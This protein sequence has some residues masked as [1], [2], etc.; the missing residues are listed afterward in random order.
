VDPLD[1]TTNFAHSYPCFCVSIGLAE[2]G[3]P[4]AGAVF[5]PVAD[6]MF[7]AARGQGAYLN[8]K[9]IQ[10]SAV[11]TLSTSLVAT[12]FPTHL[13]KRS[14]NMNYY[15]EFTLRTHGVRRDGAAA[16]DLCSVA[17]GRFDAFW[18]FGLKSWDT[19]AGVLLV[20]EAGGRV[21]DLH[22]EPYTPGGASV[23]ATN[24]RI[25]AEVQETAAIA[26]RSASRV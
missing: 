12:G 14:A 7:T 8:G 17:C 18:E 16:L 9:R 20:E 2:D 1:G 19:C 13:R 3:K 10:V 15:W 21:T 4:I 26:E 24:G 6:E 22:G 25:H 23:M 5:N 11:E